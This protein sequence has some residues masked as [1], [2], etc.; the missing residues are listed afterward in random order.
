MRNFQMNEQIVKEVVGK[1]FFAN[2]NKFPSLNIERIIRTNV[3]L[4]RTMIENE[5]HCLITDVHGSPAETLVSMF[6]LY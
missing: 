4:L 6:C 2:Y 3:L 5:N 1:F